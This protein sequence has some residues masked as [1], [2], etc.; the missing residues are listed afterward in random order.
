M[1]ARKDRKVEGSTEGQRDGMDYRKREAK[2]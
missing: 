2:E 1:E